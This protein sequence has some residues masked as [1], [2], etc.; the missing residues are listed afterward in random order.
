MNPTDPVPRLPLGFKHC[1]QLYLFGAKNAPTVR[2]EPDQTN[3]P[4]DAMTEAEAAQLWPR[5][6]YALEWS[7]RGFLRFV[8]WPFRPALRSTQALIR[9]HDMGVYLE[10]VRKIRALNEKS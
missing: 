3:A 8:S 2:H 6:Q 5:V 10:K 9:G 1:G 7:T 4:D